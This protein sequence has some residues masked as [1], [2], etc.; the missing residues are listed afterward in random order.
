MAS[1]HT[2]GLVALI[3]SAFPALVRDV[4]NT[5]RKLRPATLILNSGR[6]AAA[7]AADASQQ[8]VRRGPGGRVPGDQLLRRLHESGKLRLPG[9]AAGI[10]LPGESSRRIVDG[11]LVPR[12]RH[13]GRLHHPAGSAS[14]RCP[15]WWRHSTMCWSTSHLA[16]ALR[17]PMRFSRSSR[18]TTAPTHQ[19]RPTS[20]AWTSRRSSSHEVTPGRH[21]VGN[22]ATHDGRGSRRQ[23]RGAF[24]PGSCRRGRRR[25]WMGHQP[26]RPDR[27]DGRHVLG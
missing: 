11:R 2:A 1:P 14:R 27:A 24:L 21:R 12:H 15:G 10:P 25:S 23:A 26:A 17:E 8:R 6:A 13:A 16:A 9:S 5:E 19:P 18:D 3:W 7:T 20:S 4:P 22:L